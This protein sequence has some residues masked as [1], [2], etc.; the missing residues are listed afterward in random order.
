M[1]Q[2]VGNHGCFSLSLS[3]GEDFFGFFLFYF[4]VKKKRGLLKG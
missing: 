2:Q 4:F 3:N 1:P